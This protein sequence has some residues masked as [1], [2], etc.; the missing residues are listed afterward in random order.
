MVD[1]LRHHEE[2]GGV[3]PYFPQQEDS[4]PVKHEGPMEPIGPW[5]TGC[6]TYST[7]GGMTGVRPVVDRYSITRYSPGEWR[8]HNRTFF[9]ESTEKIRE[10]KF[11]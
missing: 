11:V 4:L 2:A 6:V 3:P 5:A 8:A 1:L 9:D 10:A 7:L